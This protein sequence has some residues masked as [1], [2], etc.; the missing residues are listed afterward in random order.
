M[1]YLNKCPF[2]SLYNVGIFFKFLFDGIMHRI[3]V[4]FIHN[5]LVITSTSQ[6]TFRI[7]RQNK[8]LDNKDLNKLLVQC[9]TLCIR[10]TWQL[11][12]VDIHENNENVD[13]I[14]YYDENYLFFTSINKMCQQFKVRI[15]V[16]VILHL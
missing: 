1:D 8:E 5:F 12:A 3:E 16:C 9:R 4:N 15:K 2:S 14:K 13:Y 11:K 7:F 6:I 10:I